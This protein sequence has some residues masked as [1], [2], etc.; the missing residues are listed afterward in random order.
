MKSFKTPIGFALLFLSTGCE[1]V[2]RYQ[3]AKVKAPASVQVQDNHKVIFDDVTMRFSLR[4][5]DTKLL[6]DLKMENFGDETATMSMQDIVLTDDDKK[7]LILSKAGHYSNNGD[8]AALMQVKEKVNVKAGETTRLVYTFEVP[9][10]KADV[11]KGFNLKGHITKGQKTIP[12]SVSFA[13][14]NI[15]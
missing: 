6:L 13:D 9:Q 3:P 5:L 7:L 8:Y 11:T 12:L 4:R 15:Q 1:S 14:S 10:E 2:A